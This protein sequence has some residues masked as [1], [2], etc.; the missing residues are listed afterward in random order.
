MACTWLENVEEVLGGVSLRSY[1]NQVY[2]SPEVSILAVLTR[3][4]F[5]FCHETPPS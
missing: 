3:F 5:R 1:K 2:L 4:F